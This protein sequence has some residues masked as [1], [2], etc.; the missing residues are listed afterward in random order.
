MLKQK[1][2]KTYQTGGL[3]VHLLLY[4]N[5]DNMIDG[6]VP[7]APDPATHYIHVM[8]PIVE[9]QSQFRRVYVFDRHQGVV[10]YHYPQY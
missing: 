10:L 1:I 7:S 8:N 4:F 6:D 9:T 2:A 3:P 5:N